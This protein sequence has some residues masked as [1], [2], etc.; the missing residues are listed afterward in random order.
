LFRFFQ[1]AQGVSSFSALP[2]VI[3]GRQYIAFTGYAGLR[4]TF[5]G[6]I[7]KANNKKIINMAIGSL[8][9]KKMVTKGGILTFVISVPLTILELY[10]KDRFTLSA[11]AGTLSADIM[12][13]GVGSLIGAAMGLAVGAFT[14]IACFPIA[15]AIFFGGI[16]GYKLDQLDKRYKFTEKLITT[17]EEMGDEMDKI[18][19][20]AES[21]LYRGTK[22]FFKSQGLGIPNY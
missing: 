15:V 20:Q 1:G 10:L 11:I 21:A 8:G 7:Y 12:K 2:K 5:P 3:K 4:T 19:G 14:T 16:A 18:A 6:T 9:I 22:S 13:I 17:L